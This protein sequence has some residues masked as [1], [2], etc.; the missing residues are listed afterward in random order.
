ML[1]ISYSDQLPELRVIEPTLHGDP[2]GHFFESFNSQLFERAIGRRVAFVQDNQSRSCQ[3]VLRG[4]HVQRAPHAQAKLVRVIQGEIFDVA[5]DVR[6]ESP[7][8]GRWAA[9][10]LSAD[11]RLQHWIPEGY[12][13]G[14]LV[15]SDFA[16]VLYK[17]SDYWTPACEASVAWD[18]PDIGIDWPLNA[19]PVLSNKDRA[20]GSLAQFRDHRA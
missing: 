14:F 17:T 9:C 7:S 13:H 1:A 2:R 12:A 6:A 15:L 19:P 16:D 5:V 20:A 4:L 3:S 8:F 18:D 10:R 11:N